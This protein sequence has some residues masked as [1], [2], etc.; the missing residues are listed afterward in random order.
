MIRIALHYANIVLPHFNMQI[1]DCCITFCIA[2]YE[3]IN[4]LYIKL[5]AYEITCF[6]TANVSN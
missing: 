5:I 1:I 3:L 6:V 2:D 4:P